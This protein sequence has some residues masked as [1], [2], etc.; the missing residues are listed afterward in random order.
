MDQP[1]NT[2]HKIYNYLLTIQH[3][4]PMEQLVLEE[5]PLELILQQVFNGDIDIPTH[6][7]AGR[8][9]TGT[10]GAK[11]TTGTTGTKATT[12][13]TGRETSSTTGIIGTTGALVNVTTGTAGTYEIF[14]FY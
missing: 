12:G 13:T 3:I 6:G 9:T 11:A 14:L 2:V 10:T 5:P 8:V 1:V 7:I 4:W